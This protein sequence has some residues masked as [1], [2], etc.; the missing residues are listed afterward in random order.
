MTGGSGGMQRGV[1]G[2]DGELNVPLRVCQY[3]LEHVC[4]TAVRRDVERGAPVGSCKQSSL[5]DV[6]T[7]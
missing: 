7:T 5:C 1:T 2:R 6:H 4:V 3:A